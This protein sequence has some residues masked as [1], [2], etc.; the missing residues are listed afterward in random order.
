VLEERGGQRAGSLSGGE[1]QMLAIARALLLEPKLLILDEPS[2]GLAPMIVVQIFESVSDIVATTGCACL[3]IEQQALT[4]LE[5][6][7][8][9]Y[10]LDR[11]RFVSAEPPAVLMAD[12]HLYERYLGRSG[13]SSVPGA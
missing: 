5:V 4:A 12:E 3:L 6:A 13:A 7:D 2:T 11:G 10:V 8:F 9:A 1:Q